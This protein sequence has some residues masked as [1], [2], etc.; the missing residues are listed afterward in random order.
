LFAE[1][2]LPERIEP[3]TLG[4]G[5]APTHLFDETATDAG[6]MSYRGSETDGVADHGSAAN[7]SDTMLSQ[8][9]RRV[10]TG[11]GKRPPSLLALSRSSAGNATS[12][13]DSIEEDAEPQFSSS[14]A[15]SN[16]ST[17]R[18]PALSIGKLAHGGA[19]TSSAAEPVKKPESAERPEQHDYSGREQDTFLPSGR[20]DEP[21]PE[22]LKELLSTLSKKTTKAAKD[23]FRNQARTRV[24]EQAYMRCLNAVENDAHMDDTTTQEAKQLLDDW[25]YKASSLRAKKQADAAELRQSL[26]SQ[27]SFNAKMAEDR[28]LE[29]K[30]GL[31]S[32]I[33]PEGKERTPAAA[34]MVRYDAE[35]NPISSR[36][37][38]SKLL[39]EQ[40]Q[41]NAAEKEGQRQK[42]LN[43]ER[44]YLNRL[45]V[46]IELHN[47]MDRSTHLEKQRTLLEAWERDGHIRN[48]KKLQPFGAEPV[49]DYIQRNLA[50][51]PYATSTG[52]LLYTSTVRPNATAP[53]SM[54]LKAT[55]E[56]N[57][58][59]T[60]AGKLNMSIGY[61]PRK[62]KLEW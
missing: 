19:V 16:T 11:A 18:V 44:D 48:L 51:D 31:I 38:V 1:Q 56:L 39:E 35:G 57:K 13:L 46:E 9:A 36:R 14:A 24:L 47:A 20:S 45:A 49:Q 17:S 3:G 58:S 41:K 6:D 40:I 42:T 7:R 26:D 10:G 54:M 50:T 29:H 52:P 33:L 22:E 2:I 61:D 59:A 12:F 4:F 25:R 43:A 32:C 5:K 8:T 15:A 27:M 37:V 34:A 55:S 62:P 30:N 23:E 60:L 53:A 28:R 21:M